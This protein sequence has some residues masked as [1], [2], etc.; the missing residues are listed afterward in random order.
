VIQFVA[1]K[2][3]IIS[4]IILAQQPA[5]SPK[6]KG[7]AESDHAQRASDTKQPAKHQDAPAQSTPIPTQTV[8]VM[9][10]QRNS[11]TADKGTQANSQQTADEDIAI[12]RKLAWF[13]GL[14]V[15]V[16][17]LQVGVMYLT[18]KVYNRQAGIMDR[19]REMMEKQ[20]TTM[21]RQ[22][23]AMRESSERQLRAYVLP[24]IGNVVNVAAPL[25]TSGSYTPT[26][27][28]VTHPD[29]GPVA[30]IHIK[31]T[32]Q[33]PA[34]KV[35]HW[36]SMVFQEYPLKS[37]LPPRQESLLKPTST[38][39]PGIINT[40][41]IGISKALTDE[42]ISK[43]RN[44][45]AAIYVYGEISYEDTF[46]NPH[47]TRYRTFHNGNTGNIGITTDL[48]FAEGGNEAD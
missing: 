48:T 6:S 20:W 25:R 31:N 7:A 21:E 15:F 26:D 17:F 29:W 18:W 22:L 8:V 3:L 11:G 39:G 41:R 30:S 47:V 35:S 40:K 36:G 14:L 5:E 32:G 45:T 27:A 19:Q 23:A 42:E 13:T 37:D 44:S 33:T 12:E 28:R 38:I 1:M 10:P 46:G 4:M 43:L 34:F 16:G 24:E 2:W 9:V